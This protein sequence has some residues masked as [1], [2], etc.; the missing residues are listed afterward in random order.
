M[1]RWEQDGDTVNN[2]LMFL[3][4]VKQKV[5]LTKLWSPGVHQHLLCV[6]KP[7]QGQDA[8]QRSNAARQVKQR[9]S[10]DGR[11]CGQP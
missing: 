11:S 3:G 2:D 10:W 5:T 4:D 7:R 1:P 9:W 8:K 6:G